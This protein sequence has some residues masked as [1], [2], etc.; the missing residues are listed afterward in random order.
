MEVNFRVPLQPGNVYAIFA[1]VEFAELNVPGGMGTTRGSSQRST[2]KVHAFLV[3][4]EVVDWHDNQNAATLH[5]SAQ[6]RLKDA[7]YMTEED[8]GPA[9]V[10]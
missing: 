6:G 1:Y 10:D 9:E 4:T 3:E 2:R 5:A 8:H 7:V